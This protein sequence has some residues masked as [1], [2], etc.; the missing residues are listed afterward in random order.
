MEKKIFIEIVNSFLEE[1]VSKNIILLEEYSYGYCDYIKK[2][3]IPTQSSSDLNEI[4]FFL[5]IDENLK[6][7]PE[8]NTYKVMYIRRKKIRN[9]LG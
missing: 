9:Y 2:D 1:V 4:D 7:I 5:L 8:Y 3:V 6:S